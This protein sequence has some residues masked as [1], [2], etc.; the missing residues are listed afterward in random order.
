MEENKE[1]KVIPTYYNGY[2]FRSRL[3]ARIAVFLDALGVEYEYEPEGYK[4]EGG[5]LPDFRVKC[6]GTRGSY[7]RKTPF[8]LYI[9]VKG[10]MSRND[11]RKI[12]QFA[13]LPNS[14]EDS[15]EL[16][17]PVLVINKIPQH[18][19]YTPEGYYPMD[20]T[21]IYPFNYNLIDGDY[22]GAYPAAHN[23]KFYLMG[24]DS[25]YINYDDVGNVLNAWDAARQARFEFGETPSLWCVGNIYDFTRLEEVPDKYVNTTNLQNYI[26]AKTGVIIEINTRKDGLR[27]AI[28]LF[29]NWETR[30]FPL[31]LMDRY[32][33]LIQ[34]KGK[35]SVNSIRKSLFKED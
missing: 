21:Y 8:D 1:I 2:Y 23:G 24:D 31:L 27:S 30:K 32:R 18:G 4:V 22:F 3:E 15:W 26:D 19:D 7:D 10:K 25:N 17:N 11:A 35:C 12:A 9:E 5:Y 28:I 6:W 16:S 29:P 20:G 33:D 14:E 34:L 13:N